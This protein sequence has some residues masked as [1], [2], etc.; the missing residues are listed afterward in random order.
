MDENESKNNFVLIRDQIVK[1]TLNKKSKNHVFVQDFEENTEIIVKSCE[2]SN[3]ALEYYL[4]NEDHKIATLS[5]CIFPLIPSQDYVLIY[6]SNQLR[7]FDNNFRKIQSFYTK[8]KISTCWFGFY[9]NKPIV[10]CGFVTGV[11]NI[12]ISHQ[13]TIVK[14]T[15]HT[16]KISCLRYFDN[17]IIS[18]SKDFSIKTWTISG[19]LLK[20]LEGHTSSVLFIDFHSEKK[21]LASCGKDSSIKIWNFSYCSKKTEKWKFQYKVHLNWVYKV[22][23]YGNLFLSS[24]DDGFLIIW[25]PY[26]LHAEC[27][28]ILAKFSIYSP[29]NFMISYLENKIFFQ[30]SLNSLGIYSFD[31][32][33]LETL[34][35]DYKVIN[36]CSYYSS[37]SLNYLVSMKN[38]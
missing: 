21:I 36:I 14:L 31:S 3:L 29:T 10:L 23:F 34:F 2:F 32:H 11:I 22:L 4:F 25:K 17:K 20:T 24:G 27:V 33:T 13:E 8:T 6:F 12:L 37:E 19:K 9:N 30:Q 35:F 7:V 15:G 5:E 28:D 26:D 1:E 18:A 16:R 38:L